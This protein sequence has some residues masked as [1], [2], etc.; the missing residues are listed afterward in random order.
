[1][2]CRCGAHFCWKCLKSVEDCE[3]PCEEDVNDEEGEGEGEGEDLDAGGER[4]W[5]DA[6][7]DFGEEPLNPSI[8]QVWSCS[9]TWAA[10]GSVAH[11]ECNRCFRR[12]DGVE[13]IAWECARCTLLCCAECK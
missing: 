13:A 3:A 11:M 1:M 2:E 5:A 8:V 7:L 10:V 4:R 9:H 12:L 6:G